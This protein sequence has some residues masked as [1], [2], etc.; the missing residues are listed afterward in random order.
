MSQVKLQRVFAL[1]ESNT[2]T[3]TKFADQTEPA[4]ILTQQTSGWNTEC[5]ES[6]SEIPRM[7]TITCC[8]CCCTAIYNKT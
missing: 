7:N 1:A 8:C 5:V 2:N 3:H 6:R 4:T